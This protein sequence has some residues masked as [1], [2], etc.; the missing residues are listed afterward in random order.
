MKND[1]HMRVHGLGTISQTISLLLNRPN[2]QGYSANN[3]E[4][5]YVETEY[6]SKM[7]YTYAYTYTFKY[8]GKGVGK[9]THPITDGSHHW[10]EMRVQGGG[11]EW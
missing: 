4:T 10:E 3:C 9:E 1:V 2:K 5:L 7:E 11:G 8:K 6:F